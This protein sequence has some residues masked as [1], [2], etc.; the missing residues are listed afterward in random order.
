MN[1]TQ[2]KFYLKALKVIAEK[3]PSLDEL[4]KW[5]DMIFIELSLVNP[6]ELSLEHTE[7]M[8]KSQL[9]FADREEFKKAEVLKTAREAAFKVFEARE[10]H[11][12]KLQELLNKKQ[13]DEKT[14]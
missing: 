14:D 10:A 5:Y 6:D 2:A 7:L 8:E 9:F 13:D 11:L 12:I 4:Y 1:A 3:A